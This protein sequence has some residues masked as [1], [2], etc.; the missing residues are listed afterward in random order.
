MK[1]Y[2]RIKKD[3]F[4]EGIKNTVQIFLY[5]CLVCQQIKGETIKTL[6]LLQ[7]LA[8]PRQCWEEVS[9]DFITG[10]LKSKGKIVIMVVVDRL[11]KYAH[12]YSLSHPFKEGVI[13]TTFM[14]IVQNLHE[15]H[16]IVVS[17]RDPKFI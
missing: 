4:W 6:G 13:S 14:E 11:T 9:M 10:L 12:F 7:A 17:D 3:F 16:K 2:H 1:T 15:I 5:E 8:I